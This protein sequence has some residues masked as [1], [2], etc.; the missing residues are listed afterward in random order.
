M[1]LYAFDGT[2]NLRDGRDA[3]DI[4]AP[5]EEQ[6]GRTRRDTAETNIHRLYEYYKDGRRFYFQ[7]VGTR[8]GRTGR[9][10]GGAFGIGGGSE[11]VS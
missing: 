10:L 8:Y 1:A 11:D 9:I 4:V 3:V 7:G 5:P 6:E 2:W